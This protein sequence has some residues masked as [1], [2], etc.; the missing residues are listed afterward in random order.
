MK[1]IAVVADLEK[2]FKPKIR[3]KGLIHMS[4]AVKRK[5]N[6]LIK[7]LCAN[8]DNSNCLLLLS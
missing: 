4:D 2:H 7:S 1:I 6:S 8:Y 5:C 3:E